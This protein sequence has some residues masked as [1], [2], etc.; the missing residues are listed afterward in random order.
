MLYFLL[1]L[2]GLLNHL[3]ELINE[4]FL[5]GRL[6]FENQIVEVLVDGFSKTDPEMLTG[7]TR[8][9]KLVNFKGDINKI[10]SIVNVKITTSK[11]WTLGGEEVE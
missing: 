4:G 8:H 2:I 11:T 1:L 9:N 3:N 6:R 10:G 5:K 7:Y